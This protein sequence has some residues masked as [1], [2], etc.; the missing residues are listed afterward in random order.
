MAM[1]RDE[2]L[3]SLH[4]IRL[5]DAAAGGRL[6]DVLVA[7]GLGLLLAGVL[8]LLLPLFARRRARRDARSL[9]A[10]RIAAARGLPEEER[11]VAML[12]LL[13]DT[14]PTEAERLR[15][16]LYLPGRFPDSAELEAVLTQ[17]RAD[18]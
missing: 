2:M 8:G 17:R 4:G 10:A 12:H 9:L 3:A 11:A 14:A 15:A 16:R 7:L 5:P 1:T 18:A 13:R 6:A